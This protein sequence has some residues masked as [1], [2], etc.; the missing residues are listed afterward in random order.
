MNISA[1]QPDETPQ[2]FAARV[3]ARAGYEFEGWPILDLHTLTRAEKHVW[4]VTVVCVLEDERGGRMVGVLTCC[5][6]D[7]EHGELPVTAVYYDK[8]EA[9]ALRLAFDLAWS[10][11]DE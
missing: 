1:P 6:D 4:A 7:A 9:D 11:T 3:V 2:R 10:P 8:E 5:T